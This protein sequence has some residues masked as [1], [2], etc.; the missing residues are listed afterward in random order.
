MKRFEPELLIAIP[1]MAEF[2][3]IPAL[4]RNL[5]GQQYRKFKVIFCINQP[6]EWWDIPEKRKICLD[7][8]QT[9]EYLYSV[10]KF[11]IEIIDHFSK[12]QGW[13]GKKTG[14]G[15]AR[16]VLF[17]KA[18]SMASEHDLLVSLDADTEI[19]PEYFSSLVNNLNSNQKAVGFSIPYFHRLTG[20]KIADRQILRYEIYMR[21]YAVNM[22]RIKNP[23][24]FTGLGSAITIP[25]WAYKR[26]GGIKP[27]TSGEDFYLLQKLRKFGRIINWNEERVYPQARYSDRVPFGTGPAMKK[28][29]EGNWSSYPV[30]PYSFFDEVKN[31]YDSFSDL[32]ERN[33]STPMGDFLTGLFDDSDFWQ[34]LRDNAT[35]KE[36]FTRAC[37]HKIDGLRILQY[38]KFRQKENNCTDES[39]LIE[40]LRKYHPDMLNLSNIDPSEINFRD[41]PV[42]YLEKIRQLLMEIEETCQK[43]D[44]LRNI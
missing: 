40:F 1:V 9:L 21:Y 22:W 35:T 3:N 31:T 29:S 28:G 19:A 8:Q 18:V 23:Y 12:G 6:D 17:D 5:C 26:V 25:V 15:W 37:Q 4:I 10:R 38:L 36:V 30:Y 16:K 42:E 11:P 20:E 43:E 14:V 7:N 39:S 24:S 2:E 13:K 32:F 27:H 41:N 33:I 44:Y 34:P